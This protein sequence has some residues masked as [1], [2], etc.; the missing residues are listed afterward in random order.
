MNEELL[1]VLIL[2]GTLVALFFGFMEAVNAGIR[3]IRRR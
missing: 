3:W 1:E 2:T